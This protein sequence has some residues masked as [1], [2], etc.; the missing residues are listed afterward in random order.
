ME[1]TKD[2]RKN[3]D[4][5]RDCGLSGLRRIAG[6]IRVRPGAGRRPQALRVVCRGRRGAAGAAG[7][8]GEG[9]HGLWATSQV[10]ALAWRAWTDGTDASKSAGV[11]AVARECDGEF[12]RGNSARQ[13]VDRGWCRLPG[14]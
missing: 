12:A 10:A 1:V 4:D 6:G 7:C 2:N 3:P 8:V 13:D 14:D 5:G 11:E 9:L